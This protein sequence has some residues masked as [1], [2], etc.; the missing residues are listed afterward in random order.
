MG[1]IAYVITML[2]AGLLVLNAAQMRQIASISAL[3][4]TNANTLHTTQST[5]AK[6]NYYTMASSF[7]YIQL[8]SIVLF[9]N[10]NWCIWPIFLFGA[11][12]C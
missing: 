12:Y 7:Y 10:F 2:N 1:L 4:V 8:F 11:N 3:P 6:L 5:L 9:A